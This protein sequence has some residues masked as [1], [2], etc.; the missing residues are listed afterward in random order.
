MAYNMDSSFGKFFY[1]SSFAVGS[2]IVK[3]LFDQYGTLPLHLFYS[4][5]EVHSYD[6][7]YN[8]LMYWLTKQRFNE[9]KRHL[10][11]STSL[12]SGQP[13]WFHEK[14]N[15]DGSADDFDQEDT[16]DDA[17][18]RAS[19]ANTRP[20]LWMPSTGTHWFKFM[21]RH[22]ALTR[23]VEEH[24]NMMYTRTEKLRIS[25]LGWDSSTLKQL[26][27]EARVE[28]S[29]KEQGKT[30]IYRGSKRAFDNEFTWTRSISRPARP[31]STVLLE[32]DEKHAFLQDV[33]QYLHP[34]TMRW[35]SDRGIPYRRG[36]LFYG[37][38][39]TG[40]SSLA[41]AA[42]GFL[43][44]NVYIL[45]LNSQ[46]L[47]EDALAQLFQDLP[48]R[49]LVLLEDIDSNEVTNRRTAEA[50]KKRKGKSSLSLSALLNII[51]GVAAQEG[52][53]L[54]MT[55]NHH[56][57]LDPALIR[58]GRVDY[59]LEFKLASRYLARQMFQNIF[60]E[61]QTNIDTNYD[62][63]PTEVAPVSELKKM[64]DHSSCVWD[65]S[66]SLASDIEELAT[67]FSEKLPEYTFSPAEIQGFL[68]RHKSSPES[69]VASVEAWVDKTLD[70]K[71]Q[72]GL[73][74]VQDSEEKDDKS[75]EDREESANNESDS[76]QESAEDDG[77]DQINM[78]V[79]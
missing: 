23:E 70:E 50:Q 53:A 27:L 7:A 54:I 43:G 1:L 16:I 75:D 46:Q 38:P 20:L 66:S 65:S 73:E 18:W 17:K 12:T 15:E 3:S 10:I 78:R 14:E 37:P 34:A 79:Q 74:E 32:E 30:V 25:C 51:D 28:F 72:R 22:L 42:A 41:F 8:Y 36:Y 4:S 5:I 55:T 61:P 63:H 40:K 21:G 35:Y 47:T 26:M 19:F 6:E 60:H 77:T 52:R 48:R 39:G 13:D 76:D 11:A 57:H 24:N 2:F 56:E 45:N 62:S 71:E 69:A 68:L 44:L 64:S 59:Q 29:Q 33:Q 67:A 31:L 58:P 49:C 9:N